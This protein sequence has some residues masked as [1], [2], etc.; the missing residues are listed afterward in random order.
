MIIVGLI[1]ILISALLAIAFYTLSERKLLGYIQYRKGPNKPTIIALTVPLGDANK[2]FTKEE[3]AATYTNP[4][5]QIIAPIIIIIL[6][7]LL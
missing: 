7:I 3:K 5:Y 1:I 4:K 6:S 2:L